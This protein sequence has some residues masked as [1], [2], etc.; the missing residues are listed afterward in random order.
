MQ[1]EPEYAQERDSPRLL[2]LASLASSLGPS[3]I[4]GLLIIGPIRIL[5]DDEGHIAELPFGAAA[6]AYGWLALLALP[7]ATLLTVFMAFAERGSRRP[8][9]IWILAGAAAMAPLAIAWVGYVRADATIP[10][11]A[12]DY[13]IPPA[14]LVMLGM[15]GGA[16]GSH[17]R[18]RVRWL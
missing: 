6:A 11:P 5:P 1:R 8:L 9:G 13:A 10:L 4:A 12:V 2:W 7:F 18:D 16:I 17:V 14:I 15:L 3:A